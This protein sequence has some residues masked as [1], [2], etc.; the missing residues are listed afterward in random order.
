[1]DPIAPA[2]RESEPPMSTYLYVGTYTSSKPGEEHREAGILRYAVEADGVLRY[3]AAETSGHNPSFLTVHPS[4][5]FLF[6]V[7]ELREGE[8]SAFSIDPKT[9]GL[10]RLNHQP[11]D[12]WAPCYL[13]TDP[14]GRWLLSANY[15]NG[16]FAVHPI[17]A[18]GRLGP[19]AD[20]I[21]HEGKGPNQSRQERA[22][23]HSIAF[24]PGGNFVFCCDLGID[25]VRVYR[26]DNIT[27]K[28]TLH[29]QAHAAPGAGPRHF[30][31]HPTLPYVYI[32]N[33]LG[34]TVTQAAWDA[35]AGTVT[36]MNSWSTLPEGYAEETTVADIHF[37]PSGRYLYVSNRGHNS[38]AMY[39]VDSET[40]ELTLLGFQETRGA[41]PRN[42]AI[43]P[44]GKFLYAANQ[45]TDNI[46]CFRLDE[47][48]GLL[49][50]TGAEY[51]A[52]SPVCL[53]FL[54]L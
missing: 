12:G 10:T 42:F 50:A 44:D 20:H 14:A 49:S 53:Q 22:H 16:S 17:Q 5:Q 3:I 7:N 23:A 18:D 41:I 45:A 19:M 39:R 33:E 27:G 1:M 52:P 35:K 6:S 34:N 9:G 8:V 11:T 47:N 24:V 37:H 43:S 51:A 31:F 48:S 28:L 26:L 40:G 46:V 32:A 13:S 38:L 29:S 4:K 36:L 25:E 54:S 2:R 30:A 21:Q 15:F